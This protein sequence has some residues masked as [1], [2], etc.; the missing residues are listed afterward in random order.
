MDIS[1][2]PIT[3]FSH[4]PLNHDYGRKSKPSFWWNH[5]QFVRFSMLQTSRI[6]CRCSEWKIWQI[7][8]CTSCDLCISFFLWG[9]G[10]V[11]SQ[12]WDQPTRILAEQ[13]PL[14][15]V[16]LVHL[17]AFGGVGKM[18]LIWSPRRTFTKKIQQTRLK[19]NMSRLRPLHK[20]WP[21]SVL[22]GSFHQRKNS[23]GN[24]HS[25]FFLAREK[26]RCVPSG[27]LTWQWKMDHLKMYSLLNMGIFHC[28][29]S[30]PECR[31]PF[32]SLIVTS[33]CLFLWN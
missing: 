27:K 26:K 31:T 10:I 28:H 19:E 6:F 22:E 2:S 32:V 23:L 24:I 1:L 33:D 13:I 9:T 11:S 25:F 3:I 18:S 21:S 12:W 14:G 20:C 15:V 8:F 4:F 29:V 17:V 5:M 7:H 16:F 30:L